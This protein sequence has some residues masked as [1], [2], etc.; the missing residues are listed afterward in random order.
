VVGEVW[1]RVVDQ[2]IHETGIYRPSFPASCP[3]SAEQIMS[4]DFLPD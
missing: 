4:D 2:V 1:A 3:W